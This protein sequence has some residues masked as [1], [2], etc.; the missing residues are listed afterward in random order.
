VGGMDGSKNRLK[1]QGARA[2]KFIYSSSID[3]FVIGCS[4]TKQSI[5]F[6]QKAGNVKILQSMLLFLDQPI[7]IDLPGFI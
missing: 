4:L 6:N 3:L 1:G 7:K 2:L 5:Y